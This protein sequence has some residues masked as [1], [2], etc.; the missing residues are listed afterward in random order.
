MQTEQLSQR[1]EAAAS[2]EPVISRHT[3][4]RGVLFAPQQFADRLCR[5]GLTCKTLLQMV[6][7]AAAQETLLRSS[8][9]TFGHDLVQGVCHQ[10]DGP[11]GCIV[12]SFG[13]SLMNE[14]F[15]F[16]LPMRQFTG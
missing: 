9:S 16:S 10:D 7:V 13:R 1:D 4:V 6:A 12:M 3:A 8:V 2:K 11:N 5:H 14:R 15:I